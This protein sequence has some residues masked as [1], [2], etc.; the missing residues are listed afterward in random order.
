MATQALRS[1]ERV[2]FVGKTGSGKTFM[3]RYLTAGLTRFVAFDP[4]GTIGLAGANRA[5]TWNVEDW[6]PTGVKQL[7]A[8]GNKPARLRVP[9]PGPDDDPFGYW[10]PFLRAIFDMGNVTLYI[11]E[12]Y[13][14]NKPGGLPSPELMALYTR[15]R[16][17]GIGVYA[18]TQRPTLVP[19]VMLSECE[20]LFTFRLLLEQDRKRMAE[21]CGPVVM[22]PIRTEHGYYLYN[23]AWDVPKLSAGL[24]A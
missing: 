10:I 6:S 4:K 2:A 16:E 7:M 11:D 14:V 8:K 22:N 12:M 19:L 20:W 15:G 1:D 24:A 17:L 13:A 9:G 5:T 23:T 21:I 3:A 18:A